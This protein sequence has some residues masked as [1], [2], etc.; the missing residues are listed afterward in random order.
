MAAILAGVI[1]VREA[2][3]EDYEDAGRVTAEAYREFVSHTHEQE[4]LDYLDEIADVGKRARRATVL[5]AVEDGQVLGSATLELE[6]PLER[7]ME[8]ER[9]LDPADARIRMLGVSPAER[10]RGVGQRLLDACI[11]RALAAGKRRVILS[12][13]WRMQIAQRMYERAGFVRGPNAD[14]ATE[15]KVF[16]YSLALEG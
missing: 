6:R 11:D 2:R 5:V 15:G 16:T 14:D 1:E 4:W 10:G 7:A 3:P 12:T 13:L 9:T 8:H